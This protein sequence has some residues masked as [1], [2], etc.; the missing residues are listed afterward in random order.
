MSI[1]FGQLRNQGHGSSV[2]PMMEFGRD[3]VSTLSTTDIVGRSGYKNHFMKC[4]EN[5]YKFFKIYFVVRFA[6]LHSGAG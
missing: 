1:I 5:G 2:V 3:G 4:R 6:A